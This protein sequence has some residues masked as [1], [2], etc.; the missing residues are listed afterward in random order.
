MKYTHNKEGKNEIKRLD[1]MG[2]GYG[3]ILFDII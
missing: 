2:G 1:S 3:Y